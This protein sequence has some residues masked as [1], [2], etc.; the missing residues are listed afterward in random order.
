MDY[1]YN[2]WHAL[3]L[4]KITFRPYSHLSKHVAYTHKAA[5]VQFCEK[6]ASF[7]FQAGCEY[8]TREK[9]IIITDDVL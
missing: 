3:S 8:N 1:Y 9:I 6:Y 2:V 4:F 7:A 5:G